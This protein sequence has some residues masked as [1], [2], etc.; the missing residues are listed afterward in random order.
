MSGSSATTFQLACTRD[1]LY[2]ATLDG[3]DGK[4]VAAL[5]GALVGGAAPA[6][7]TLPKVKLGSGPYTIDLHLAAQ[8]NP[9]TVTQQASE[10]LGVG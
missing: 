10:P 5:R 6:N 7:V 3:A 8:V 2:V 9:G 4:P 1:C